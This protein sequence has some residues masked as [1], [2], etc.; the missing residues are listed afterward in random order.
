MVISAC[1]FPSIYEAIAALALTGGTIDARGCPSTLDHTLVLGSNTQPVILLVDPTDRW[2]ITIKDGSD[3][4]VLGNR[5]AIIGA[6]HGRVL[7]SQG[8]VLADGAHVG[9]VITTAV[10][11]DT[12]GRAFL[13]GFQIFGNTNA[14]VDRAMI[15]LVRVTDNS[16]IRGLTIAGFSNCAGLQFRGDKGYPGQAD[17]YSVTINGFGLPGARPLVIRGDVSKGSIV[18]GIN[19][20][21]G[22]ITHPGPGGIPIIDIDGVVGVTLSG[23]QIESSSAQDIG[24][25]IRN[26]RNIHIQRLLATAAG[27]AGTDVVRVLPPTN[28]GTEGIVV[29]MVENWNQWKNTLNDLVNHVSYSGAQYWHLPFWNMRGRNGASSLI[30]RWSSY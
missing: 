3:A 25:Q 1:A 6:G 21:G 5:S 10:G 11:D 8:F 14:V 18:G 20:Y 28:W 27:A 26:A 16:I 24:V 22:S 2:A 17:V 19:I 30:G 4:I 13:E 9:A 29:E 7:P 15:D 12:L 23:V